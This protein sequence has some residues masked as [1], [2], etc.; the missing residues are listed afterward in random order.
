MC[1]ILRGSLLVLALI[2]LPGGC[3]AQPKPPH[4]AAPKS[5]AA[6]S[7]P[8]APTTAAGETAFS[9]DFTNDPVG[10]EP[11]SFAAVVGTWYV[12]ADGDNR[13]LVVDGTKWKAGKA[14]AGLADKARALYGDRYGEFL[15]NVTAYAYYPLAV[16]KGVDNFT[17]GEISM[18]FRP[19]SGH[20]DQNAGIAF[21]VKPNGDYLTVRASA[22][23]NN[24][25]LWEYVHGQRTSLKWVRDV[26]TASGQWHDL[27][28]VVEGVL[29]QCYLDGKLRL[30]HALDAPVSGR[31]GIWSKADGKL[32]FDD[33]KV[34]PARKQGQGQTGKGVNR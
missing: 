16:A 4:A 28:L 30:E 18:R 8:A 5:S 10:A 9:E 7:G 2:A 3:K 12:G 11:T 19:V 32:Y 15:D 24:V 1:Q 33:Y 14:S 27:K 26:P 22:L 23:E 34:T 6:D 21:D 31:V 20:I 17:D 25:I 29:V 13:V